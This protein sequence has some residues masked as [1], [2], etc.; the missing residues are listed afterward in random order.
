MLDEREDHWTRTGLGYAAVIHWGCSQRG[1][2]AGISGQDPLGLASP[3]SS[4]IPGP[5]CQCSAL[6]HLG[7]SCLLASWSLDWR[8]LPHFCLLPACVTLEW[9]NDR[10]RAL[11]LRG[12]GSA[13]Q[14]LCSL[15]QAGSFTLRTATPEGEPLGSAKSIELRKRK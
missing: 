12:W 3:V 8:P 4:P 1:P 15:E 13:P 2:N 14:V 10:L 5:W 6:G 11:S 7:Y 9:E